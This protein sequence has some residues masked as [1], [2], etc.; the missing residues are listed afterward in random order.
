MA[1]WRAELGVPTLP[2][3][4]PARFQGDELWA[5]C[6]AGDVN[7]DG[8]TDVFVPQIYNLAYART[9]LFLNAQGERFEDHAREGGITRLDTYAGALADVDGD[10]RLD[11]VTAG[12]PAVGA[13]PSLRL[14]RNTGWPGNAA[15]R[16]WLRVHVRPGPERR[17]VLGTVAQIR[18][19]RLTLTRLLTAGTS[20]YGQQ[21][22]P[23]LHFG[24]G[25]WT[26]PVTLTLRWP[27]GTEQT[28]T[29]AV[30]TLVQVR[31]HSPR[32]AL[33]SRAAGPMECGI[34]VLSRLDASR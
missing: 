9:K 6:V 22:D 14:Y 30:D 5:G 3:G 21:D 20:T 31:P 17:T 15:P 18:L 29:A 1:D 2:I 23:V 8:W 7:N 16:H 33:S 13:P 12:R 28:V 26:G 10:G 24:L 11:V 27:D 25:E 4:G 19:G 32:A 34:P